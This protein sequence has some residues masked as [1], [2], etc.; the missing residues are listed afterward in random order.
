MSTVQTTDRVFNDSQLQEQFDQDGFVVVRL[1]PVEV[2]TS[3][4]AELLAQRASAPASTGQGLDQSFFNQDLSY[5]KRVDAL[6]TQAI[7]P[8]LDSILTDSRLTA[9]GLVTKRPGGFPLNLHRDDAI[10]RDPRHVV[11]NTWCAL[12]PVN[13]ANGALAMLR[14][15]HRL[16]NLEVR[17]TARFYEDYAETLKNWTEVIELSPGE[18]ILFDNRLLHWSTPN[19]TDEAR[20][21]LRSVSVPR[22]ERLVFFKVD[23]EG[24]GNRFEVL[25]SEG[26]SAVDRTV[27]QIMRGDVV[28]PSLGHVANSNRPV[29]LTECAAILGR[30]M[31]SQPADVSPFRRVARKLRNVISRAM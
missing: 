3:L 31:P 13:A 23:A 8:V 9:C 12:G 18:A 10:L 1:L 7:G 24:G 15:S 27:G 25:A 5:R 22:D 11:V 4:L 21:A 2:A 17:G 26:E 14:G 6:G 19:S 16:P 28:V 29:T 20:H 30:R